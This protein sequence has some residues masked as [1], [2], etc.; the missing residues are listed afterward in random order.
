MLGCYS[1]LTYHPRICKSSHMALGWF[2]S[3]YILVKRAFTWSSSLIVPSNIRGLPNLWDITGMSFLNIFHS[4][5]SNKHYPSKHYFCV[6]EGGLWECLL[7]MFAE[8]CHGSNQVNDKC[9]MPQSENMN[10][11]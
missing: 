8:N 2:F 7:V 11:L 1:I 3:R 5:D 4:Q 6:E 10:K 9:R